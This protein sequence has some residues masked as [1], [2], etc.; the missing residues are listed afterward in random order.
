MAINKINYKGTE[1]DIG[2]N[3]YSTEEQVVGKWIDGKPL[4]RK[5]YNTYEQ[6]NSIYSVDKTDFVKNI[7]IK[8]GEGSILIKHQTIAGANYILPIAKCGSP[9]GDFYWSLNKYDKNLY[10][11]RTNYTSEYLVAGI[12]FTIYYTKTT[13]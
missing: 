8:I 1:F 3:N 5:T 12:E 6:S 13:D 2:N 11:E 4:Y 9:L 7:N 10:V